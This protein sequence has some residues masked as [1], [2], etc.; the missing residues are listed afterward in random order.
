MKNPFRFG[1]NL[2][3]LSI[4]LSAIM[5][6]LLA[7]VMIYAK[8]SV[9]LILLTIFLGLILIL[10][11]NYRINQSLL[12]QYGNLNNLLNA[13]VQGDYSLRGRFSHGDL[14]FNDLIGLINDLAQRLNT[15]RIESVESQFLVNIVLEHIDTAILA[16]DGTNKINFFNS[17]AKR[18]LELNEH[19]QID[20]L[21]EQLGCHSEAPAGYNKVVE[22]Q[23]KNQKGKYNVNIEEYRESGVKHK[24]L[25][26]TDVRHLLRSEERR[27]WQRLVRVISHEINNSLT[28]IASISETLINLLERNDPEHRHSSELISGLSLIGERAQGLKRFVESYKQ[29]AKLPDP[30]RKNVSVYTIFQKMRLLFGEDNIKID[31]DQALQLYVDP[32]QLEQVVINVFKNAFES[33]GKVDSSKFVEVIC[34][35]KEYVC[36]IQILDYGSGIGKTENLF[37][38]FYTTKKNGSGIGLALCRQI[39]EAHNGNIS[40]FNRTDVQGCC[41]SIE[42]PLSK[43]E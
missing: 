5:L 38:P 7:A 25:F 12:Y 26:I 3:K 40:I 41:V 13:L 32:V 27:A 31:C 15:Q 24:I 14:V 11:I 9:W 35:T 8:I 36:E 1:I 39:I 6:F 21:L 2:V 23:L 34:V 4:T 30:Q 17:S 29:L 33:I 28:P 37:I 22:L 42:L 19:D 10:F 43:V 16:I 20:E 18:L